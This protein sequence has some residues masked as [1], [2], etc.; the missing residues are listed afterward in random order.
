MSSYQKVYSPVAG[1]N[2]AHAKHTENMARIREAM[3]SRLALEGVTCQ[4]G[5]MYNSRIMAQW[6]EKFYNTEWEFLRHTCRERFWHFFLHAW[7]VLYGPYAED[8]LSKRDPIAEDMADWFQE[9]VEAWE[10]SRRK[11]LEGGTTGSACEHPRR[12]WQ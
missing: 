2:V 4:P 7:G 3:V 11:A 6:D 1:R 5:V 10:A 12:G 8:W 9:Q